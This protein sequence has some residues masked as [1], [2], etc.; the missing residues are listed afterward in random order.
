MHYLE[1]TKHQRE[2]GQLQPRVAAVHTLSLQP[3]AQAGYYSNNTSA[4]VSMDTV[5][6]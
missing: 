4:V 3:L 2:H 5:P 1:I 6:E